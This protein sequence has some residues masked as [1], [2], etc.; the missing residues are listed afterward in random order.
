MLSDGSTVRYRTSVRG[1]SQGVGLC[2]PVVVR[3]EGKTKTATG[4]RFG[5]V[6]LL[7]ITERLQEGSIQAVGDVWMYF[8]MAPVFA[9]LMVGIEYDC[10]SHSAG[11][12]LM[13]FEV[14]YIWAWAVIVN[15]NELLARKCLF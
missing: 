2:W 15:N 3:M 5:F 4:E 11:H 9:F 10:D 12:N 8:R 6:F 1:L 7:I 14:H 13:D